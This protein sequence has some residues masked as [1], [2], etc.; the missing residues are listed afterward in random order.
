MPRILV[1][2][3]EPGIALGLEDSL[4]LDGHDVDVIDNGLAAAAQ[5]LQQPYDLLLLDVM[6]PGKSGFD[7]CAELRRR[8]MKAPIILLTARTL[9]DDRI[10]GLDLGANDY[11]TKPF[12]PRELMARVRGLLRHNREACQERRLREE[13]IGSAF[14]VQQNLFPKVRPSI[15]NLDYA[16]ACRPARG[17]SGDYYDFIELP[18]GRLGLLLA[19]VSGKGMPAALLGAALQSAIKIYAAAAGEHCGEVLSRANRLI[20]E[21]TSPEKY[22]TVFY[23]VYDPCSRSLT[24]SNAGHCPPVVVA[25]NGCRTYLESLTPP[26]G[27]LPE[28]PARERRLELPPG[29]RFLIVSDGILEACNTLDEEF[30]DERLLELLGRWDEKASRF[31][32]SVLEEVDWFTGGRS[33]SDDMTLIAGHAI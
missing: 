28:L 24:Y 19:D 5:A 27:L 17:V 15:P 20:F 29:S 6:L 30:G 16:G 9:E 31:C 21:T 2:E 25:S 3:D 13:E 14:V 26:V 11:V 7:I 8:G 4:R 1:V 22:A 18:S 23:A 12:S 32:D 33:Q 10:F